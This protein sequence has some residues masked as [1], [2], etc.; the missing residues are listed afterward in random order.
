MIDAY[1]HLDMSVADPLADLRARMASASVNRALVVETWGRDNTAVLERLSDIS[2]SEFRIAL[3][4]RSKEGIPLPQVVERQS[5]VAL[6]IKTAD[7][8]YLNE[9]AA[10]FEADGK[11][12]LP[13]AE[14]GIRALTNELVP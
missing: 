7:L 6:R 4:Y 12:L 1:A 3:C 9:T 11:W 14:S 2:Q 8:K 13:H 10:Y 5:V